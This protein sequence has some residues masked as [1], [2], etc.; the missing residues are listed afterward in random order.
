MTPTIAPAVAAVTLNFGK[1][2]DTFECVRSLEAS[3]YPNL[4]IIVVDNGSSAESRERLRRELPKSVTFIQSDHNLGFAGGNNLGIRQA[5]ELGARYILLINND[6]TLKSDAMRRMIETAT[7]IDRL[8]ILGGKILVANDAGPTPEIWSAGGWYSP[9]RASGYLAGQGETDRG[10]YEAASEAEFLPACMWLVPTDV[11]RS[12]G[13][14]DEE[15][16]L[17]AEDLDYSLKLRRAGYHLYY[18][19]AAVCFHKVSR[20]HWRDRKRASPLLNYY[21]NRNRVLIARRWLSAPERA[22]F[23]VYF[24]FSRALA[25]IVHADPS[26]CAGILDGWRGKTGAYSANGRLL[27]G[28]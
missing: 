25:A 1:P 18:E 24:A 4:R 3:G 7:R 17:Y 23:Y 19:P 16:F 2:D 15:F 22:L 10:Q 12:V 13:L 5:M 27:E 8:G 14:L 6:A 21:T 26:Y 28:R 9:L 11:F 20:S